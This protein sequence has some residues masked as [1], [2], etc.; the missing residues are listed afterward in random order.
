MRCKYSHTGLSY[1]GVIRYHTDV[2]PPPGKGR[3]NMGLFL[4]PGHLVTN[5]VNVQVY[6]F[7]IGAYLFRVSRGSRMF[8]CSPC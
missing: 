4:F 8:E 2:H 6:Y 5:T 7:D 3:V 1:T